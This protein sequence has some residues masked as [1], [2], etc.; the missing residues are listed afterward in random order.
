MRINCDIDNWVCS[1]FSHPVLIS[2]HQIAPIELD[3]KRFISI[4][5]CFQSDSTIM[6]DDA[7]L[8]SETINYQKKNLYERQH[9]RSENRLTSSEAKIVCCYL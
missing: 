5:R 6:F 9:Q 4:H 8:Q 7:I 1:L 3:N 2:S